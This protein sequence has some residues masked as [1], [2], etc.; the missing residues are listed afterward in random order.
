MT[1]LAQY[2]LMNVSTR[3]LDEFFDLLDSRGHSYALAQMAEKLLRIINKP[4]FPAVLY[5]VAHDIPVEDFYR[6]LIDAN[7]QKLL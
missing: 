3:I 6:A 4:I 2:A 5:A 1:Q 7:D